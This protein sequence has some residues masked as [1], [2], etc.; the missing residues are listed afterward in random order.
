M[1]TLIQE[2]HTMRQISL[3][4]FRTRGNKA[5]EAVPAGETILLSGQDGPTFFLIPVIGDV[6][7]EDRELRRAMAKANLRNTWKV[8]QSAP[9][10][11]SDADIDREIELVRNSRKRRKQQ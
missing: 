4:E 1:A 7:A 10:Q 9:A 5:I 2:G 8:A 3:R 6:A 11:L